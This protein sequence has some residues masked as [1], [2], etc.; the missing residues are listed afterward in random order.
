M[1]HRC[2][3]ALA[4]F[5][6]LSVAS[7]QTPPPAPR[8]LALTLPAAVD[9]AI[10]HNPSFRSAR[11]SLDIAD[12]A[13]RA[14]R[15]LFT[16]RLNLSGGEQL[17]NDTETSDAPTERHSVDYSSIELSQSIPWTGA[18][19][20]AFSDL[21]RTRYQ[22]GIEPSTD[23]TSTSHTYGLRLM[24]PLLRNA[25]SPVSRAPLVRAELSRANAEHAF[26]LTRNRLILTVIEA[27]YGA[28]RAARLV[29]VSRRGLAEAETHLEH[30]RIRYEEGLVARID[31]SQAE[32]Q[33]LRQQTSLLN[34]L[35]SADDA[36]DALRSL[37]FLPPDTVVTLD[38]TV[39]FEPETIELDA[40]VAEALRNRLDIQSLR[41]DLAGAELD[42]SVA[43]N[44]RLP[45]L[46]LTL[47]ARS[48]QDGDD[49]DGMVDDYPRTYAM[50]IDFRWTFGDAAPREALRQAQFR[51]MILRNEIDTM[52]RAITDEVK[53]AI[54]R[55]E[56]L[57]RTIDVTRKSVELAEYALDLSNQSYSEGIIRSTDLITSQDD[58]LAQQ[59]E[60]IGAIMEFVSA[61]AEI[62]VAL[63]RPI[64]ASKIRFTDEAS[65]GVTE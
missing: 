46:D 13:S 40:A 17:Q 63:G 38:E 32:I 39:D 47:E 57:K 26:G 31:V 8:T 27:Y 7:S 3:A 19:I 55:Y 34:T 2:L 50:E 30:T 23:T 64:D 53:R 59:N 61:K 65:D 21:D 48:R 12:S 37:L 43:W 15:D 16:P 42:V 10:E 4:F 11:A 14:T 36:L 44:Q 24:Q 35:Q 25:W 29:D 22:A 49:W 33:L 41:N 51:C 18:S 5:L 56:T 6:T 54:R 60:Y 58:L 45:G 20:S 62:L 52:T 1:K 9:L 28:A